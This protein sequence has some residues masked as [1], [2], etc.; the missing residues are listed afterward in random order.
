MQTV[1]IEAHVPGGVATEVYETVVDFTR[2]PEL[3]ETVR[4][5]VAEPAAEDGSITSH[6][7]VNFR[8]G[9][10]RWTEVDTFDREALVS[11]F[12][13]TTGDFDVFEGQWSVTQDGGDAFVVF[14]A[15]FDF[16]VPTLASI[17]DPVAIRVLTES[18][19]DIL[20]GLFDGSVK[21]SHPERAA[22][23]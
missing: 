22:A 11:R 10:L 15:E 6:W 14:H 4:E 2:Y 20:L 13:Q 17:I 19:Q 16:G 8:N 9:V 18:M 1:R 21:F 23:R 3:V 12:T 5:V 7:A